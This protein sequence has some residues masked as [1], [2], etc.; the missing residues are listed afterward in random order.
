MTQDG[1]TFLQILKRELPQ[2]CDIK[3]VRES[4]GLWIHIDAGPDQRPSPIF[5][6]TDEMSQTLEAGT[7]A[8]AIVFRL[9]EALQGEKAGAYGGD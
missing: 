6:F 4:N 3:D 8:P 1:V 7:L 2:Y 5:V 9:R